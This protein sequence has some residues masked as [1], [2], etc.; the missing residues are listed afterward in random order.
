MNK[1]ILKCVTTAGDVAYLEVNKVDMFTFSR[2]VDTSDPLS[3]TN[4]NISHPAP[5]WRNGNDWKLSFL[6]GNDRL[7]VQKGSALEPL[8]KEY[9]PYFLG[10][11]FVWYEKGEVIEG[12]EG[13]YCIKEECVSAVSIS[14]IQRVLFTDTCARVRLSSGVEFSIENATSQHRLQMVM[15]DASKALYWENNLYYYLTSHELIRSIDT[16]QRREDT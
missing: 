10:P 1:T 2:E 5:N 3:A 9:I 6:W 15:E 16:T 14:Q 7:D 8:L 12:L 4:H 13:L 11:H